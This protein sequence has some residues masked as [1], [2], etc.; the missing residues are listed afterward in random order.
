MKLK[1][2]NIKQF[3]TALLDVAG[4]A[5][6]VASVIGT[7]SYLL[8]ETQDPVMPI[9]GASVLGII[10]FYSWHSAF[11]LSNLKKQIAALSIALS[12]GALSSYTIYQDSQYKQSEQQKQAQA[13]AKESDYAKQQTAIEQQQAQNKIVTDSLNAQKA[14]N[15]ALI[16]QLIQ[17]NQVDKKRIDDAMQ[18]I[19]KGIKPKTN[20][21][22]VKTLNS[23]IDSRTDDIKTLQAENN[24]LTQKIVEANTVPALNNN[25][26]KHDQADSI[27][28]THAPVL[29]YAMLIRASVYDIATALLLLLSAFYRKEH[30]KKQDQRIAQLNQL[31][32]R[33]NSLLVEN[34]GIE[35]TLIKEKESLAAIIKN[36]KDG[37]NKATLT[38]VD[39]LKA[40]DKTLKI[41]KQV[42]DETKAVS[43]QYQ[44]S[45]TEYDT[46]C[47]NAQALV[48]RFEQ[49]YQEADKKA[50]LFNEKINTQFNKINQQQ[51]STLLD[52]QQ[53]YQSCNDDADKK[54]EKLNETINE[55]EITHDELNE[56]HKKL[57]T[58]I[59]LSIDLI[60]RAES[61]A[62]HSVT[63]PVT[64]AT[65]CATPPVARATECATQPVTRATECV[66]PPVTR[67]TE[68]LSTVDRA[69]KLLKSNTVE[70]TTDGY[71][72]PALLQD[73]LN[74]GRRTAK[75]IIDLA[76]EA[77]ILESLGSGYSKRYR[78][79]KQATP[80]APIN[81]VI[82]MSFN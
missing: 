29:D 26:N 51:E 78:Y 62:E 40:A 54:I 68:K 47:D 25:A 28:S 32:Q 23:Q 19:E 20:T 14:Q 55:S 48:K 33:L 5:T 77:E 65:E 38:K 41:T 42:Q 59:D 45:V 35:Q 34:N 30:Q 7:H 76:E 69:L 4:L 2:P 53:R 12:V 44:A 13:A 3:N 63:P 79:K 36:V 52:L 57:R 46:L 43:Q 80:S 16:E 37:I 71:I 18:S 10:S 66:T 24:E 11:N 75:K 73:K 6:T 74:V 56:S 9:A 50:E 82:P 60:E 70:S 72:T 39:L 8:K 27:N 21:R 17:E 31:E 22:L 81:N 61:A 67:A 1:T 64:R 58:S 49:S 15:Q